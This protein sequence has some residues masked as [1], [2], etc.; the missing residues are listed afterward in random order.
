MAETTQNYYRSKE[1]GNYAGSDLDLSTLFRVMWR[2]KISILFFLILGVTVTFVSL[3][4][5]KPLYTSQAVIL[6]QNNAGKLAIKDLSQLIKSKSLNTDFVLTEIEII[7]SRNM[8]SQ[9]VKRLG[10]IDDP[11]LSNHTHVPQNDQNFKALLVDGTTFESLPPETLDAKVSMTINKF[12]E[13]LRVVSIPGSTAVQINFTSENPYKSAIITNAIVDIYTNQKISEQTRL[14]QRLS[15][16]FDERLH[17][18]REQALETDRK[19]QK[20][21]I[22]HE[23]TEDQTDIISTNHLNKLNE[24]LTA[25]KKKKS[26]VAVT[27]QQLNKPDDFENIEALTSNDVNFGILKNLRLEELRLKTEISDLSNRYGPKHPV[28]KKKKSEI[29]TIQKS[30]RSEVQEIKNAL[31]TEIKIAD[32]KAKDLERQIRS[33]I[34]NISNNADTLMILRELER[35]ADSAELALRTFL[36][37]YKNIAWQDMLPG[38]G[39]QVISD[40]SVPTHPSFPNSPLFL[41]LSAFISLFLGMSF[42]IFREHVAKN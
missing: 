3:S 33:N 22:E 42:A 15:E 1:P 26:E 12:L 27:L 37:T 4:Y 6:I 8:V 24:Q 36:E 7:K 21:K 16:W 41:L 28:I 19:M 31:N 23:L 13:R 35:E 2:R 29:D 9:V 38:S 18:L 14:Q 25:K 10:L 32:A 5:M 39:V 11:E 40:A 34:K 30:L 20:Y 17:N